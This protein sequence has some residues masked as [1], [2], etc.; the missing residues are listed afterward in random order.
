A[1]YRVKE[2]FKD[3]IVSVIEQ[4]DSV[5]VYIISDKR[6]MINGDLKIKLMNFAGS[7]Y[8][9]NSY[10]ETVERDI[11]R[12][13]LKYNKKFLTGDSLNLNNMVLH[14]SFE[15]DHDVSSCNYYFVDPKDLTLQKPVITITGIGRHAFEI[16]SDKLAKNVFISTINSEINLS[17]NFFDLLPGERKVVRIMDDTKSF[18][19]QVKKLVVKSLFDSYSK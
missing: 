16:H 9:E 13:C 5:F 11:V 12:C 1:H 6:A 18:N 2:L 14:A 4:Y 10:L 19:L 8:F 15:Y 7:V 3:V 17:D